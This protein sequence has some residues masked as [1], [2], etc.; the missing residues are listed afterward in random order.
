MDNFK[1]NQWCYDKCQPRDML[2]SSITPDLSKLSGQQKLYLIICLYVRV[3][4]W[5]YDCFIFS[6][7]LLFYYFSNTLLLCSV[8]EIAK[9]CDDAMQKLQNIISTYEIGCS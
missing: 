9:H 7:R 8:T 1:L 5:R 2:P 4:K 6:L 3:H